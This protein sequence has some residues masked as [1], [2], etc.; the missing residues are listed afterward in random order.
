MSRKTGFTLLELLIVVT[1]IGLIG[2]TV[3]PRIAARSVSA[4]LSLQRGLNDLMEQ[5]A[6][7]N[8]IRLSV[9]EKGKLVAETRT[10]DPEGTLLWERIETKW[11]EDLSGKWKADPEACFLYPDGTCS[12][13]RLSYSEGTGE[14]E[15]FQI[16]VTCTVY[17]GS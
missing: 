12:P 11:F 3:F 1:L 14:P 4:D 2:F 6:L 13:W 17:G 10:V 9:D 8:G 15:I 16:T 5:E 7:V